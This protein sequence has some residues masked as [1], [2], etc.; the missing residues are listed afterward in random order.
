MHGLGQGVKAIAG[1]VHSVA[2]SVT[3]K[4][5]AGVQQNSEA[6]SVQVANPQK[7]VV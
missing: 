7:L 4:A 6:E 2:G 5:Q 3:A 1:K